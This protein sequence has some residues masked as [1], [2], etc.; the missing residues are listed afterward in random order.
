MPTQRVSNGTPPTA[1]QTSAPQRSISNNSRARSNRRPIREYSP[2]M[3]GER[4]SSGVGLLTAEFFGIMFLLFIELFVGTDSYENKML[5]IMKRGTLVAILFFLLA[6][7]AGVG[8][9]ASKV[10]KGIGA[11]VFVGIL[12]SSPGQVVIVALDNF[13]KADWQAADQSSSADAGTQSSANTSS[14]NSLIGG[15]E[16]VLLDPGFGLSAGETVVGKA[17]SFLKN[18]YTSIFNALKKIP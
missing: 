18:E 10:A 13:F 9:N 6:I 16:K 17:G 12:L 15:I 5:S 11:L 3:V 2:D 4:A 7:I 1:P 14:G 8:P